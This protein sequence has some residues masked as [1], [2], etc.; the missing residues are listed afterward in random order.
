RYDQP[1]ATEFWDGLNRA[2]D[3][4]AAVLDVGS[5]RRPTIPPTDRPAGVHYAGL[6]V[7]ADELALAP[8][9][10]YD[11]TVVSP[12]EQRVPHLVGRFDLIVSWGVFEHLRDLPPAAANFRAYLKPGGTLVAFLAGRYAAYAIANRII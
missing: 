1:W 8:S 12:A 2:L 5:G 6:D 4:G 9:G 3:A 11:E 10:S 7:S